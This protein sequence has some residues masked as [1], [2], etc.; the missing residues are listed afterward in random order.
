[1]LRSLHFCCNSSCEYLHRQREFFR[2]QDLA[3]SA[4]SA[5]KPSRT[6]SRLSAEVLTREGFLRLELATLKFY[7][8]DSDQP[9]WKV[10]KDVRDAVDRRTFYFLKALFLDF[11]S[12]LGAAYN[13][14][15][16]QE[17]V[18]IRTADLVDSLGAS[19]KKVVEG[20][21]TLAGFF[22]FDFVSDEERSRPRPSIGHESYQ[23]PVT[24]ATN[25]RSRKLHVF[26]PIFLKKQGRAARTDDGR[27]APPDDGNAPQTKIELQEK[28]KEIQAN[29]PS[30]SC[31]PGART[32]VDPV[33]PPV[34][35]GTVRQARGIVARALGVHAR[36]D[37]EA[38]AREWIG[39]LGWAAIHVRY[40]SFAA[41]WNDYSRRAKR[42]PLEVIE[43]QYREM[44]AAILADPD[45]D[46]EKVLAKTE[47]ATMEKSGQMPRREA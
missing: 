29:P 7:R 4:F 21:A 38:E 34:A 5:R 24:S 46:P 44:L 32:H 42:T 3:F 36:C 10:W 2:L 27:F 19:K 43:A 26:Y 40:A 8:M 1:M 47:G 25:V 16:P 45:F 35:D 18:S 23:P 30:P 20:L 31:A 37:T 41:F 15:A 17:W 28:D 13:R 9:E 33:R 12:L 11:Y 22:E 14:D 6:I 39:E